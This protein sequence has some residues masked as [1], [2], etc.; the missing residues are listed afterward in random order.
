[1]EELDKGWQILEGE[2]TVLVIAGHNLTHGRS[3]KMKVADM[4]TGN[5]ARLLC[6]KYRFWGIVSTRKQLDPNWYVDS[7]FR[8]EVKKLI[9]EIIFN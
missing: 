1:M 2:K 9:N 5:I 7:P 8:E 6:E 3:G 4:G